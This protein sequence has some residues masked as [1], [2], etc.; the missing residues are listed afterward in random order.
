M[1]TVAGEVV[2]TVPPFVDTVPVQFGS[3]A[4]LEAVQVVVPVLVW[5]GLA[6]AARTAAELDEEP[7][8]EDELLLEAATPVV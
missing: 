1:L 4:E 3:L 8:P 2:A 6:A 7:L 5:A